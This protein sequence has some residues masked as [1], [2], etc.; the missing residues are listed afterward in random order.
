MSSKFNLDKCDIIRELG[1]GMVG[2]TYLVK[3]NSNNYALKIEKIP[4]SHALDKFNTKYAE[5]REIEF[6]EKFGNRYPEQF[7]K[8][9]AYDVINDCDFDNG[10][11]PSHLPE[12]VQK[13]LSD[14]F[15]STYCIRK[16]Y[17]LVD[18]DLSKIIKTLNRKQIY[19]LVIQ[20]THIIWLLSTAGYSH[21]D[22]HMGNIGV[23]YTKKKCINILNNKISIPTYGNIFV[24]L[25]FGNLTNSSWELSSY[26]KKFK[27]GDVLR[28]ITSLINY[29]NKFMRNDKPSNKIFSFKNLSN[30]VVKKIK[31]T[32]EWIDMNG[33]LK[34]S[35]DSDYKIVLFQV[36]YPKIFQEILL[37]DDFVEVN[38]LEY[39][40]DLKDI[41]YFI[42][43]KS[44][45]K[46][47]IK[48]F[49]CRIYDIEI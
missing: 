36:L 13:R 32:K 45:L 11:D 14:K 37:G 17:S 18:T 12:E 4:E 19:S 2:T 9:Y 35:N 46:K 33:G 34:K 24:A 7:I 44:N 31:K 42:T 40:I 41:I 1:R 39:L 8:L 49:V 22:L 38:E 6:S 21:N 47:I 26:E 25:D 16:L 28:I 27:S 15:N 43:H 23:I 10:T 29:K 3:L 5:W 20:R 48:Y 30:D